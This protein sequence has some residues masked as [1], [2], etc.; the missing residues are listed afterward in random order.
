M[1]KEQKQKVFDAAADDFNRAKDDLSRAYYILEANGLSKDA[2][3]LF[4]MILKIERFETK[5]DEFRL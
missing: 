4:N 1:K 2:E 5:Y 3:T